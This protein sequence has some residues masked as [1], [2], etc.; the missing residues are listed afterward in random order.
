MESP[1]DRLL[2]AGLEDLRVVFEELRGHVLLVGGL[3]ARVWLHLRPLEDLP[4][5]ATAD[6][7]LGIDRQGLRL[8]ARPRVRP[9]LEDRDYRQRHDESFR[10]EKSFGEGETLPV[11]L[12]VPKGASRADPP[13]LED[14][15]TTLA[16]PGLA[17]GLARGPRFV[18]V[19]FVQGDRTAEVELPLPQL[20][21]A[22]VMKGALAASGVRTRIDRRRRDRVDSVFL[23][24]A[25]ASDDEAVAHLRRAR[26]KEPRTALRWLEESLAS[27]D[28]PVAE[29]LEGHLREEYGI[30]QGD[31]WAVGVAR[32]LRAA[33]R[34]RPR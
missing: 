32:R 34:R 17:Y 25:C 1:A 30:P 16:A 15:I 23:A 5:R 27:V 22:F 21:A 9:L 7:D 29:A 3:M 2:V 33:V 26:T 20:D 4:P 19:A 11:D 24:A 14:G 13:I 10:F 6:I 18:D 31:E 12:F 8:G 28:S